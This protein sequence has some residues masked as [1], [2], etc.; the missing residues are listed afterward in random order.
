VKN[1]NHGQDQTI[2]TVEGLRTGVQPGNGKIEQ[3]NPGMYLDQF[4]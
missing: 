2:R 3:S 4:L 1:E